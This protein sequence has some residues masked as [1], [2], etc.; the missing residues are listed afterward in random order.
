ML[1][2]TGYCKSLY[3]HCT[4]IYTC[5]YLERHKNVKRK[6]RRGMFYSFQRRLN[7][8][9]S[10]RPLEYNVIIQS[11]WPEKNV[12]Q[13]FCSILVGIGGNFAFQIGYNFICVQVYS[14]LFATEAKNVSEPQMGYRTCNLY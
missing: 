5:F 2:I 7:L 6:T 4:C 13:F 10:I 3:I 9:Y 8:L 12:L 11:N 14:N 1:S